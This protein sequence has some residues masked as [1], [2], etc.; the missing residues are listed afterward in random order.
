MKL[1]ASFEKI[2]L[3]GPNFLQKFP[4][5]L[6][7][8]LEILRIATSLSLTPSTAEFIIS[9]ILS[10]SISF[11]QFKVFSKFPTTFSVVSFPAK[12]AGLTRRTSVA[13]FVSRFSRKF[14]LNF[15]SNSKTPF[16]RRVQISV[17]N[18]TP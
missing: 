4:L 12:T 14:C 15:G 7:I 9:S 13:K 1:D 2:I 5:F 17:P 6:S 16:F 10:V 3:R 11:S 8:L 18:L